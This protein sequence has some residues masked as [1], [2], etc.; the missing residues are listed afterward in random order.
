METIN[1]A[2]YFDQAVKIE[3]M[4]N[5]IVQL[6]HYRDLY[7][8]QDTS[9]ISDEE[10][11][12]L[13]DQL[14]DL[15]EETG[16]VL[17]TSPTYTVGYTVVSEL[18]K[19][20]HSHPMLSLDKTKDVNEVVK[21]FGDKPV[22]IM[23]KMDGLTCSLSYIRGQLTR[24]ETRGDG[25]VGEDVT[26]NAE[27]IESI[28]KCINYFGDCVIDGEIICTIDE[29]T[30]INDELPEG[31]KYK[32]IRNYAAGSIRNLD[33]HIAEKRHLT[34]VAWRVVKGCD[35]NSFFERWQFMNS[36]GFTCVPIIK[37]PPLNNEIAQRAID[38][39]KEQVKE[40]SYPI[41][42]CVFSYEDIAYGE[43]LGSTSHHRR[44]QLAFK[45]YDE[46]I[47][48]TLRDVE[49]TIG[50]T[51]V[52]TPTAVFAPVDIDGTT[53]ER[54][55][56]HNISILKTLGLKYGCTVKVY[57]ANQII[58]QIDSS[59]NDGTEDIRIPTV[60]PI[61][62]AQT[63]IKKDNQTEVLICT[64][65]HC[66][67]KQLAKFNNFVSRKCANIDGLSE[68][69]LEEFISRGFIHT[70]AD[71]YK[72]KMH[73]DEIE[74]IEGFGSKSVKNLLTAIEASRQIKLENYINAIGIDGIGSS[75]AKVLAHRFNNSYEEFE[76]AL[77]SKFDFSSLDGF[78]AAMN[79]NIYNWY[80]NSFNL[81]QGLSQEFTF[82]TETTNADKS[83]DGLRF[84]ITG[85]F[86][87]PREELK[88]Q[89]ESKGA[90]FVSGV[91]SKLDVLFAGDKA[92]SKLNKA[93]ELG[94]K[95]AG[96]AE[97]ISMLGENN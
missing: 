87:K 62:G 48:T 34:F 84:C 55:S 27:V 15:E 35:S 77:Q 58:P 52:L 44:D 21:Y 36:L 6:N 72:L 63:A 73:A 43:S 16:V 71:I 33:S 68:A 2:D 96:E 83:L 67:G 79:T 47:E 17:Q 93:Q 39:I 49:W 86:S 61:C 69:T 94:I 53:V 59:E 9:E 89:L 50:K 1:N 19:V 74:T 11:D 56:V 91:S 30:Q 57:K 65:T 70:F 82:I 90:I 18:A 25:T 92:G 3:Q 66:T 60:C 8:N 54:A 26:H 76:S 7:Y 28:P 29:Y 46:K 23:A 78:G 38:I 5:L 85:T 42:G 31:E 80:N 75:N 88:A 13:Y 41:D 95:V 24:A 14:K 81:S 22:S 12:N 4:T 37:L 97:L 32:H 51:G 10:Y 64:N 40:K 20:Y 45:F